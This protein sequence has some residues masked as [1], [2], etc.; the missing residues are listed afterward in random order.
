MKHRDD[1]DKKTVDILAKRASYICSNPDCRCLTIAA[2]E[3][4]Q[5]KFIYI[6]KAAH[7]TAASVDGPRFNKNLTSNERSDISNGIFLCSNCA[8]MI[9]KNNGI[10]FPTQMLYQWK[11]EHEEWAKSN[12]NK[13]IENSIII[14]SG[15]HHA[16]GIGNVTGLEIKKSAIIQ[17]GTIV[18]S[19]GIGNITGTKIG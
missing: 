13:S 6:G 2:S 5:M 8:V 10:D 7:I 11:K 3:I 9:D 17:P 14:I 4:D 1:F 16:K 12:L 15:E 18:T 19:E